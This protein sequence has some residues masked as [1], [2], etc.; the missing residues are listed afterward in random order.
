MNGGVYA[1]NYLSVSGVNTNFNLYNNGTTYLNGNTTVDSTFLVTNGNVGIGTTS[2]L[3]KLHVEGTGDLV[4]LVSTNAGSGGAQMD[5]LQFSASP[6]DD[7]VMGLI[8]MGGYYSGTN[9][10][11]FS[12]IRTIAT[13]VSARKGALTFTTRNGSDFTEKMRITS[14]ADANKAVVAIGITPSNWYNYIA[15]QVGTG[16]LQSPS[17]NTI[18]LG[19]NYYVDSGVSTSET[20]ITDGSATAYQQGSGTHAWYT[21]PSGTA[22]NGV[23]FTERM[24]ITSAGQVKINTTPSSLGKL[25][26]RSDS[27]AST[28]YNNIQCVPSD[29]TTG[30][31]FIGSNV[32]ND[33]IMVTGAYYQN[34]GY[35]TPTS[36]SASII[37]MFSGNIVFKANSS[38]TVGTNYIPT[39]RMRIDSAGNVGI[40]TT[41]PVQKLQL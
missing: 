33:A 27:G 11:Y 4:R 29:S 25:S 31:L 3:A 16:S 2:P 14:S 1:T 21:A 34:A 40:G 8:N 26:V 20:Y 37:N 23:T 24:R 15:L 22:G 35:Y 7:D 28:F 19:C 9:S 30:G 12:S 13:D 18:T 36:T 17:S 39:E 38:L 32:A 41:S 10:A 5:M 6:A